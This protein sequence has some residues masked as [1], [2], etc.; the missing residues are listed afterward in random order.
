MFDF[1]VDFSL[2]VH[3]RRD[4]SRHILVPL[5]EPMFL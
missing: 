3:S 2:T 4:Y 1:I 5:R